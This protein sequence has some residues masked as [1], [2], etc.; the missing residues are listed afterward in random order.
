MKIETL[1]LPVSSPFDCPFCGVRT[2]PAYDEE[3]PEGPYQFGKCQHLLYIGTSE[4]GLEYVSKEV[5]SF[6]DESM[7]EDDLMSLQN[8]GWVHYSLHDPA[9]SLLVAFVGYA[10]MNHS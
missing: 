9:P 10:K 7:D 1:T 4:G 6:L 2:L 3:N 5:G 8:E